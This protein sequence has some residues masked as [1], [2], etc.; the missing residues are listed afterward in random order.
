MEKLNPDTIITI[1]VDVQHDFL[2][3]GSLAVEHGDEVIEPLNKLSRLTRAL[4]GKVVFTGDQHPG[5]TPHFEKWPIHC[6]AGTEGAKLDERLEIE[7]RDIIIDKGMGQTDGYSGFEGVS[8]NGETLEEI[9]TPF[10]YEKVVV[11]IGGL[12]LDYCVKNTALDA[13]KIATTHP[14]LTVLA[15]S[16]ATRAVNLEPG[17][18]EKAIAEMEAAGVRF[19]TSTEVLSGEVFIGKEDM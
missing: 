10:T 15:I 19:V 12:A 11:M 18:D 14:D 1:N 2:P 6:I 4:G 8:K 13:A 17:D 7:A 9:V 16:D 3:G 5:Y